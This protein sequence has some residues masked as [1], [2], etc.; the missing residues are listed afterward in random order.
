MGVELPWRTM[1][2]MPI[3]WMQVA[4]GLLM[5]SSMMSLLWLVQRRTGNAGIVDV[6]WA[7]GIG[8]L[9]IFFAA[10]AD[11]Y[12][13]RRILV[14]VLITAWSTRLAIY[15]FFDRFLGHVEEGRYQTLRNKWG[16]TA[17]SRFFF[18][19]QFQAL[20]DL[21]F[22]LPVLVVAYHHVDHW[23]AWDLA[24]SLI[25]CIS[26]GNTVLADRQLAH[27]KKRPENRGKTCR[28]G[29]WRYSRH[30]NY[31]FEWLHWCSYVVLAV[32]A[33]YWWLTLLAPAVMLFFLLKV[34]GIPPTEAQA[35]ASRGDDYREYQRTTS[36]FIPWFPKKGDAP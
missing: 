17:N 30:P 13:P 15:L 31:F 28:E 32:G 11:G 33:S 25:W 12:L 20:L 9:G 2:V 14:A 24:G 5:A 35:L 22:T 36:V 27:F 3:C 16:R 21:F 29:W 10:T 8:I 4:I 19:F 6:G 23:M 7:A 26:V 34:T 1:T 18:F